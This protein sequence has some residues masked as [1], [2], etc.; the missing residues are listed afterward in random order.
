MKHSN[1]HIEDLWS[2]I[3]DVEAQLSLLTQLQAGA[4]ESAEARAFLE[5]MPSIDEMTPRITL[6]ALGAAVG[7]RPRR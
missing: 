7:Q 3:D 5:S 4:L 2:G 1:C 6:P